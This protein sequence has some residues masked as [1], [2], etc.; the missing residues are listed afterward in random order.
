DAFQP[1]DEFLNRMGGMIDSIMAQPTQH[2]IESVRIPGEVEQRL[3]EE[4][5]AAGMIPLHPAI[6]EGYHR[7]AEELGVACDLVETPIG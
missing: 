6:V 4:R 3:A 5:R 1:L 7:A 2:G